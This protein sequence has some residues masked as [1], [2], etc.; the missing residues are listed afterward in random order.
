MDNNLAKIYRVSV[1]KMFKT[2]MPPGVDWSTQAQ[3]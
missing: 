1:F 3:I 2:A